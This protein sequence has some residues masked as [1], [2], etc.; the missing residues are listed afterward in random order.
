MKQELELEPQPQF[1]F[2][3]YKFWQKEL[4][5]LISYTQLSKEQFIS[6]G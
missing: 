4:F 2:T 6:V 5:N 1:F 3:S